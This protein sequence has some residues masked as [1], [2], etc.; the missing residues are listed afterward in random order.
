LGGASVGGAVK[1]V[2]VDPLIRGHHIVHA[3]YACEWLIATGNEV[4]F[5]A[6]KPHPALKP[7]EALPLTVVYAGG[8]TR[9][10][11]GINQHTLRGQLQMRRVIRRAVSE[12]RRRNAEVVHL[13]FLDWFLIGLFSALLLP[14]LGRS[15][16]PLYA[17]MY[18]TYFERPPGERRPAVIK[19]KYWLERR[20]L[21]GLISRRR[22]ETL[23]V[24]SD[25]IRDRLCR[26]GVDP[27]RLAVIPDPVV[28]PDEVHEPQ[29][30]RRKMGL[31]ETDRLFLFFG[32]TRLDKG[33]DILL[34][35][36]QLVT[37][38]CTVV[39]VGPPNGLT[40]HEFHR[41]TRGVPNHVRLIWRLERVPD[42][43][44]AAFFSAA[45]FVV[46]PY[47]RLY[48]G[49]SG[50]MQHAA[51]YGRPI[52]VSD[53]GVLG[54]IARQHHL[55][56]VVEPESPL[57]LA[58][59]ID[60]FVNVPAAQLEQQQTAA[61]RYGVR[62]DWRVFGERLRETFAAGAQRPEGERT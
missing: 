4:I 26:R 61:R 30:A 13:L 17:A 29:E 53:V 12:A 59:A 14:P 5:I 42:A 21:R 35:A 50:A 52:I 56:L 18:W 20:M 39:F 58:R 24:F 32:E 10:N 19:L 8:D 16:I 2:F 7:L 1:V 44:V 47:R 51:A 57:A 23:F 15:R 40:E 54:E 55:G 33:P 28:V 3:V 11:T 48:L 38:K 43:E 60:A 41:A 34:A 49:T 22:I 45:D 9:D 25:E 27:A 31:P 6:W 36:L 62:N 46:L 37:G